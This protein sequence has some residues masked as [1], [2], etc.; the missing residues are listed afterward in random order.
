MT[1]P[2]SFDP[3][4]GAFTN[5]YT[6]EDPEQF[7]ITRPS[8]ANEYEYGVS[9]PYADRAM[10]LSSQA[11]KSE[12]NA[13]EYLRSSMN[14][15]AEVSESQAWA[16]ALLAALPTIGGALIGR[17]VGQAELP[18]GYYEAGGKRSDIPGYDKTLDPRYAGALSGIETGASAAG[19]YLKGLDANQEQKNKVFS[20]MAVI[21]NQKATRLQN[22]ADQTELAGLNAQAIADRQQAYIAANN[23]NRSGGRP[24]MY[25]MMT[26]EQK[27][28]YLAK[29]AG[30]DAQGKPIEKPSKE[31]GLPVAAQNELAERKALIDGATQ[32]AAGMQNFKSWGELQAARAASGFDATADMAAIQ[33]IA[34]RALRSRSGAAAPPAER[35]QVFKFVAGDLTTT[36]PALVANF[37][38]KY[39]ERER[40]FG[41]SQ[42]TT[43]EKLN[44]P[45]TRGEIFAPTKN[46]ALDDIDKKIAALEAQ[47][48]G[49][50]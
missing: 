15:S 40:Q 2:F 12:D 9:S 18:A 38:L 28:G 22:E 47:I 13:M 3:D 46:P 24:T 34:D 49:M 26:P 4:V 1:P 14:R 10:V 32:A 23:A 42:L 39:A 8:D 48:N 21:E 30:V 45:E 7:S 17:S 11:A 20:Q 43:Y 31:V 6:Q 33:D 29:Q 41:Q 27:A 44:N 19:G 50:K 36:S 35:E 25:D 37:L 5:W 16:T